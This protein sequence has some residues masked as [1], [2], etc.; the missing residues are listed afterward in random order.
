[1]DGGAIS[2]ES[3][4]DYREAADW[5][6]DSCYTLWKQAQGNGA[7]PTFHVEATGLSLAGKIHSPDYRFER[8]GQSGMRLIQLDDASKSYPK[9]EGAKLP[10]DSARRYISDELMMNRMFSAANRKQ[11]EQGSAHQSTTQSR[12]VKSLSDLEDSSKTF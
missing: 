11:R 5:I 8:Y 1:M 3:F 2:H 4:Q 9:I 6:S 10:W 7:S 12:Q